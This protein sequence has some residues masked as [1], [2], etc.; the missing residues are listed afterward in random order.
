VE[1]KQTQGKTLLTLLKICIFG[2][3]SLCSFGMHDA[4]VS[5]FAIFAPAPAVQQETA[6]EPYILYFTEEGENDASYHIYRRYYIVGSE[7]FVGLNDAAGNTLLEKEWQD[8]IV[9]PNSYA[10]KADG[11][12]RFY[13]HEKTVLAEDS[14]DTVELF[15]NDSGK[16][17]NDMLKVSIEGKYGTTDQLGNILISPRWDSLDLY[18]TNAQW[19]LIRVSSEGKYGY[20]DNEGDVVIRLNYDYAQM[21]QYHTGIIL[22]DGSEEI[23]PVIYVYD[24]GDWGAIFRGRGGAPSSVD[25]D[26]QPPPEITDSYTPIQ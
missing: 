26:I 7:P 17:T 10:L 9:L 24:D 23:K 5:F 6:G 14:W 20:I 16:I 1:I 8:I 13:S 12:W 11:K 22:D 3:A 15:K 18:G 4:A 21:G 2:I 19:P 25:W